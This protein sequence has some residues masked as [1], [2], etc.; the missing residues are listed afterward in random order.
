MKHLIST[1]LTLITITTTAVGFPAVALGQTLN[2][3]ATQDGNPNIPE[4]F[5]DD[6]PDVSAVGA[7]EADE[8]SVEITW[9]TA[10]RANG[11][12]VYSTDP[13]L[14]RQN[15]TIVYGDGRDT[16]HEIA[17]SGVSDD[18]VYFYYVMSEDASYNTSRSP[19]RAFVPSI[20]DVDDEL[21][22]DLMEL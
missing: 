19:R 14:E 20:G 21:A 6:M 1:T 17:L 3:S 7:A 9:N 2:V 15:S 5:R 8:G 10:E 4:Q 22:L 12:V 16:Q 11:K 18:T 13:K